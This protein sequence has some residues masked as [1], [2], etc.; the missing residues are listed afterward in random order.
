VSYCQ[1]LAP[2]H[3]PYCQGSAP[4]TCARLSRL[5]AHNMCPVAPLQQCYAYVNA[6]RL[7]AA[8][9]AV[10]MYQILPMMTD[11]LACSDLCWGR[12]WA[13]LTTDVMP[14]SVSLTCNQYQ[15]PCMIISNTNQELCL[16]G[17]LDQPSDFMVLYICALL[18]SLASGPTPST[19]PRTPP[20]MRPLN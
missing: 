12:L 20:S 17:L 13:L 7:L 3:A 19:T 18:L 14:S 6:W 15:H 16:Q 4:I 11:T 9:L 10:Y 5:S 1:A 2:K 8:A